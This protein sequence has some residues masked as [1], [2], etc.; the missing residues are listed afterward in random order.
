[1]FVTNIFRQISV[2]INLLNSISF[3]E[4]KYL[5]CQSENCINRQSLVI[6]DNK[7]PSEHSE[8]ELNISDMTLCLAMT[9]G[10]IGGLS[11]MM[12]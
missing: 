8:H 3:T 12:T 2:Q 9:Y 5:N 10:I 1:M 7:P 6:L 4:R 11:I